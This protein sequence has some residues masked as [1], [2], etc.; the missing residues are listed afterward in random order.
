MVIKMAAFMGIRWSMLC[1]FMKM[2]IV[3]FCCCC[4]SI[5]ERI[6]IAYVCLQKQK[7]M[8]IKLMTVKLVKTHFSLH[9]WDV[10]G[11]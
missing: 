8:L 2:Y 3:A 7:N 10:R 5:V 11:T 1:I 6:C 4:K 9:Y